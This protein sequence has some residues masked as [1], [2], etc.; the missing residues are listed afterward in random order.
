MKQVYPVDVKKMMEVTVVSLRV[1][2]MMMM[3]LSLYRMENMIAV[4]YLHLNLL[5]SVVDDVDEY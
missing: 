3:M 2:V 4:D 1:V 5:N